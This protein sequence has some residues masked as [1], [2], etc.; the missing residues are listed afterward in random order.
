MANVA[1]LVEPRF[2]VPVVVG[3]SPIVRPRLMQKLPR[4]SFCINIKR[5]RTEV[6]LARKF[7]KALLTRC[8]HLICDICRSRFFL[9]ILTNRRLSVKNQMVCSA[10]HISRNIF[11]SSSKEAYSRRERSVRRSATA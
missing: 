3:S 4:G 9:C 1:Q 5:A 7:G 2:V 11:N 6:R 10:A 8:G